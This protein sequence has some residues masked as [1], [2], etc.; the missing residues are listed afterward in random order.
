MSGSQVEDA[1]TSIADHTI[2]NDTRH[3]AEVQQALITTEGILNTTTKDF[4]IGRLS[5]QNED[6]RTLVTTLKERIDELE[7]VSK[8]ILISNLLCTHT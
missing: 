7:N 6:L 5:Q 4:E 3:D 2:R 8:V 1:D